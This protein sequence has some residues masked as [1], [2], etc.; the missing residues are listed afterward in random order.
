MKIQISKSYK[1]KKLSKEKLK[2]INLNKKATTNSRIKK[3]KSVLQF[4]L[5][6]FY[7]LI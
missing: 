6:L 3:G 4:D 2:Q 1:G 5:N 7:N